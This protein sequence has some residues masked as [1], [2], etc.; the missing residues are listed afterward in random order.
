MVMR[1]IF[2]LGALFLSGCSMS[3]RVRPSLPEASVAAPVKQTIISQEKEEKHELKVAVVPFGEKRGDQKSYG[4][5]YKYLIPLVPYGTIRYERPDEAKMFNTQNEFEFNMSENL[6]KVVVDAIRKSGL[7]DNVILTL[8]PLESGADVVL[9]GDINSTLYEGKTYS[10]GI[11]FV[12][13]VLWCL[14]LPAGS[15]HKKLSIT[16]YLKKRDTQELLWA[17]TIDK[18][19]TVIQGLYHKWG[20]EVNSFVN[21][22]AEGTKEAIV[23]MRVK[24]SGIPPERLRIKI[25]KEPQPE[26]P[27]QEAQPPILPQRESAP[28]QEAQ[29]PSLPQRVAAPVQEAQPPILPQVEAA[30][31]VPTLEGNLTASENTP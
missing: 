22:M 24:L 25:P 27:L 29:P 8:T 13:P 10:Y 3:H 30:P 20:K 23:D 7:F 17:Y 18:E 4:S 26:L 2:I 15:S 19:N 9:S 21:L 14:G 5:V 6:M 1:L 31:V 12:G 28:A 16:L 11:S